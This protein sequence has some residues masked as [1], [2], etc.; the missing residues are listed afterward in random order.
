MPFPY[1]VPPYG[2]MQRGGPRT[3][4]R[5]SARRRPTRSPI[6]SLARTGSTTRGAPMLLPVIRD[7]AMAVGTADLDRARAACRICMATGWITGGVGR[8]CAAMRAF[9]AATCCS[10]RR[11]SAWRRRAAA[12]CNS[13]SR[14]ARRTEP[15]ASIDGA[16]PARVEVDVARV[17][18]VVARVEAVVAPVFV[19]VGRIS[20]GVFPGELRGAGV[21]R[22]AGVERAAGVARTA[23]AL[24]VMA[25]S[26]AAAAFTAWR[27]LCF[28]Q[29]A[30]KPLST[31]TT[32]KM[33]SS[34]CFI[35]PVWEG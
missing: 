20:G 10:K 4:R 23:G 9:S 8:C 7:A 22:I 17:E 3:S 2:V 35:A 30:N 29:I 24:F 25:R 15:R 26:R 12:A 6:R 34:V 33:M 1:C 14:I 18:L 16:P 21:A 13:E 27:S 32:T 11:A 5:M 28:F 19:V 31:M